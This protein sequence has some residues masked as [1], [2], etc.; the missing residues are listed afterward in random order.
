MLTHNGR[1]KYKAFTIK[2]LEEALTKAEAGK[3][4]AKIMQEL[5]RKTNEK[6]K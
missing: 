5:H 1:P 6:N 2:Q 3:K 4:R